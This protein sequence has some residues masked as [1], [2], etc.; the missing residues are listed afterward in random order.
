MSEL[1]VNKVSPVTGT[2]LTLGDSGDTID[3]S[4]TTVTL[5][6]NSVNSDQYVDGSIDTIHIGNDQVTGAK[7]NPAL[8]AGDVIYADGT[9]T[10]NRLAKGTAA[11]VLAMNAGATAPEW[12]DAAGGAW[13]VKENGAGTFSTTS[14]LEITSITKTI[15]VY[16]NFLPSENTRV[17]VLT[18]TDGGTNWGGSPYYDLSIIYTNL[19]T[20]TIT[21]G[22]TNNSGLWSLNADMNTFSTASGSN[23]TA[24]FTLHS[25][26]SNRAKI[27]TWDIAYPTGVA[28]DD[29]QL[30]A[31]IG[32]GTWNGS[33]AVN[34]VK[35]YL[36]SGTFTAG[37]YTVLELN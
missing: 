10:I 32:K 22:R 33:T 19:D 14:S 17:N 20:T 30:F 2:E 6:V 18:S 34:A 25:P 7:L 16:L 12:A 29:N 1:K 23:V 37:T 24:E 8:V 15:K 11:Q 13:A 28:V 5:P 27:A 35:F 3:L 31:G 9:D 21:H 4:A 36:Q 26:E